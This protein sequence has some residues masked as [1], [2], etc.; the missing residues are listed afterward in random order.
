[1]RV[2]LPDILRYTKQE[3]LLYEVTGPLI[4]AQNGGKSLS[5]QIEVR[6]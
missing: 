3:S 4:Q 2:Q 1:M 6:V 5:M